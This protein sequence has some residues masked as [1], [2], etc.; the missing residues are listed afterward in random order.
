MFGIRSIRSK[1]YRFRQ[2]YADFLQDLIVKPEE[3]RASG[4]PDPC[5]LSDHVRLYLI[6]PWFGIKKLGQF[7]C[8]NPN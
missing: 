3:R 1:L 5:L 2:S 8:F 6:K 7:F 4:E